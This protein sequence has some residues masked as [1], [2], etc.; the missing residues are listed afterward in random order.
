MKMRRE[1]AEEKITM[2]A[3]SH[4]G[5]MAG[6]RGWRSADRYRYPR[7]TRCNDAVNEDDGS[8]D[9]TLEKQRREISKKNKDDDKKS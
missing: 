1:V 3:R 4:P 2:E 8:F 9:K 5:Q 6:I 7:W